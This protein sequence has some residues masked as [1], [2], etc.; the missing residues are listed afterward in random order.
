ML[1]PSIS[2]LEGI[3][4]NRAF[5]PARNCVEL[6]VFRDKGCWKDRD[7]FERE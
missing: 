2:L 7:E 4:I 1:R 5:C 6:L 3:L